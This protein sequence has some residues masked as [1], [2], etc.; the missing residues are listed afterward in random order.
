MKK[1]LI[2]NH[3]GV[4]N[5]LMVVPLLKTLEIS[6]P[7][8][9]YYYVDNPFFEIKYFKEKAG[10]KNLDGSFDITWR[11]FPRKKWPAI[12]KFIEKNDIDTIIN[13]RNEGPNYD[14]DYFAFR[15][16]YKDKVKCWNLDFDAISSRKINKNIIDDSLQML[17]RSGC[18]IAKFEPHWL[19]KKL[20]GNTP[21]PKIL[22]YVGSSQKSKRWGIDNWVGLSSKICKDIPSISLSLIGGITPKEQ[23]DMCLTV[24]R[25]I[26][27]CK[28]NH[29]SFS[30]SKE[31]VK[32]MHIFSEQDIIVSN[33]TFAIHL[34][35]ALNIPTI[36][37]YF[38][39]DPK[40]WGGLSDEFYSI[41]STVKCDGIKKNIGNCIH[42]ESGCSNLKKIKDSVTVNKV[43]KKINQTKWKKRISKK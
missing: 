36:G 7:K 27:K 25:V 17:K 29:I 18:D 13:F 33:D 8:V 12:I 24:N 16:K 6:F 14:K 39:T 4:G 38:S 19:N 1:A 2:V 5:G 11:S 9:K 42:F 23:A 31:L 37:L 20:Y 3:I 40:I 41:K 21:Y 30:V 22:F 28:N 15:E 32:I 43:Y 26:K 34:A 10:L 35:S